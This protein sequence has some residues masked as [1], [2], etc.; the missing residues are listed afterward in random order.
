M[1]DNQLLRYKR[2][3]LLP[4]IDVAGQQRLLDASVLVVGAG[5]LGS[6]VLLYLA[7][8]GIGKLHFYDDDTVE[9]SNIQRQILFDSSVLGQSKAEAAAERL[10]AINPDCQV[11]AVA[12]RLEG[13]I[14]NAAVADTDLVIDCSDNFSTR[15]AVN[16]ACVEN[17][18]T[19]LS[20]AVIRMEGQL[21]VFNGHKQ[22][23]P[24]YQCLYQPDAY[25]DETC[26]SSGVLGPAVGV[27]GSLLATEAVK[28]ITGIG[29]TL[30]GRLLLFDAMAMR[31]NELKLK[32]DPACPVCG[33]KS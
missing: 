28:C 2:H 13:E 12:S 4:Q 26:T 30:E 19:L 27:I 3:L 11:V 22:D 16:R 20:G 31:F 23:M 8:T 21:S 17:Q 14:L 9:I 10:R 24:C 7:A 29:D 18:K 1:D 32:K 6:P 5:G 33:L 15:F 25:D